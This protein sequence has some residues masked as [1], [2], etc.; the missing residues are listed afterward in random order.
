MRRYDSFVP[1]LNDMQNVFM[2]IGKMSWFLCYDFW[3]VGA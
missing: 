2:E 1:S 3:P